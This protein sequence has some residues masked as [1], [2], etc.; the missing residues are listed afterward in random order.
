MALREAGGGNWNG[1]EMM[2]L[3]FS[4]TGEVFTGDSSALMTFFG[5]GDISD[6]GP[7]LTGLSM[8][9]ESLVSVVLVTVLLVPG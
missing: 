2:G 4:L 1:L 3:T 9:W 6:P 5:D 8:M 7:G